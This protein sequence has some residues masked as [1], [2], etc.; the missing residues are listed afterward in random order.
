MIPILTSSRGLIGFPPAIQGLQL[1]LDAADTTT[2]TQS[3]GSVSQWNDKSGNGN[4]V[5]QG[6]AD[7]QPTTNASTQNGKNIIDF[8]GNDILDLPSGLFGIPNSNNT[9]F[10][11]AN[12]PLDT[13][14]QRVVNFEDGGGSILRMSFSSVSGTV[15]YG[16]STP[17]NFSGVTKA[18][19]NIIRG[20]ISGTTQAISVNGQAEQS[21]TSYTQTAAI[22]GVIGGSNPSSQ[23]LTGSIVTGKLI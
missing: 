16:G 19:M 3:S 1:W 21:N 15:S 20:R 4:D 23:T 8:D 18:N 17:I 22:S 6:T 11:V 12:T 10:V 9:M 7:N 14:F 5:T 13:T 2:I